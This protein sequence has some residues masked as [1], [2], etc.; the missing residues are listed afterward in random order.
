MAD[1]NNNKNAGGPGRRR[2]QTYDRRTN[3]EIDRDRHRSQQ[4][5]THKRQKQANIRATFF[6]PRTVTPRPPQQAEPVQEALLP[7]G[8]MEEPLEVVAGPLDDG[9]T[10]DNP[11][12]GVDLSNVPLLFRRRVGQ[13]MHN[14]RGKMKNDT[15]QSNQHVRYSTGSQNFPW[16][17]PEYSWGEPLFLLRNP[18]VADFFLSKFA[19]LIFFAVDKTAPHLLPT[20][21]MPCKWHGFHVMDDGHPCTSKDI[22]F[23]NFCRTFDDADSTSGFLFS[24]RYRCRLQQGQLS[25]DSNVNDVSDHR[26]YF[27]GHDPMVLR[28]L[29]CD[30]RRRLL[31]LVLTKRR[32]ITIK[33]SERIWE[34]VTNKSSFS[35]V[36]KK[37]AS[38]RRNLVFETKEEIDS[39]Y[40]KN[41][42]SQ[43]RLT[44]M[45]LTDY[46][47]AMRLELSDLVEDFPSAQ[48]V[49]R[50][51]ILRALKMLPYY[52]RCL[53][54]VSGRILCG[55]KSY[56]VIKFVF[57]QDKDGSAVRAFDSVYTVMNEYNQVVAIN[58]V[59]A[60]DYEE[61]EQILKGIRRRYEIHGY[62]EVRL[63]Y[64]DDCCHEYKMLLRAMPS[65]G[66][67]D[68][69]GQQDLRELI[70]LPLAQLPMEPIWIRSKEA[71]LT[72][73]LP[74]LEALDA[75]SE[76]T[77]IGLDIE[78][79]SLTRDARRKQF[80]ESLQLA[81]NCNG[82]QA[83]VVISLRQT[84]PEIIKD[85]DGK[86]TVDVEAWCR[87]NNVLR[88]L[89]THPRALLV[90]VNVKGDVTRLQKN[91]PKEFIGRKGLHKIE[92]CR[93]VANKSNLLFVK[94]KQDLATLTKDFM[95]LRLDK[96][97]ARSKWSAWV[98][99]QECIQYAALDAWIGLLLYQRFESM[100]NLHRKPKKEDLKKDQLVRLLVWRSN[101]VCA[102]AQIES[103][104]LDVEDIVDGR[105]RKFDRI[106]VK[107]L[108][109]IDGAVKVPP[110]T[111]FHGED[112]NNTVG[113]VAA[114]GSSIVWR[115]DRM[116]L[117][118]PSDLEMA[119]RRFP[120]TD[121]TNPRN[122]IQNADEQNN[123]SAIRNAHDQAT[124]AASDNG[125]SNA[126]DQ[127][128]GAP[129]DLEDL[130][131]PD[132]T[133][134]DNYPDR[135]VQ[136]DSEH[137]LEFILIA[138]NDD[139]TVHVEVGGYEIF[140]RNGV[141]GDVF[142]FMKRL[143]STWKKTHGFSEEARGLVRDAILIAKPERLEEETTTLS[144]KLEAEKG[145]PWSGDAVKARAEATRR[146]ACPSG[147]VLDDIERI[148]PDP[149]TLE[150]QFK[151]VCKFV[152]NVK[153]AKTG[154]PL[155]SK[156]SWKVY[157]KTLQHIQKGCLS[158]E[159]DVNYYYFTTKPNGRKVLHCCRGTSQLEGFHRH[160][161]D[162]LKAS[163]SSPLLAVCLLAA[164]VHR[165][166]HDRA[167][168]KG[169]ASDRYS[170]FYQHD[171][172]HNL[173]I[174]AD[175]HGEEQVF[176]DLANPNDFASTGEYHYTPVVRQALQLVEAA[177]GSS[178]DN[179]TRVASEAARILSSKTVEEIEGLLF[180]SADE[181]QSVPVTK[182]TNDDSDLFQELVS[183][184]LGGE[185][186]NQHGPIDFAK[187]CILHNARAADERCKPIEERKRIFGKTAQILKEHHKYLHKKANKKQTE[188][189][190]VTIDD[191]TTGVRHATTVRRGLTQIR[192]QFKQ[193][194]AHLNFQ[195]PLPRPQSPDQPMAS[196]VQDPSERE[197]FCVP[198][199][200]LQQAP[201]AST[202]N[203]PAHIQMPVTAGHGVVIP[204]NKRIE[205]PSKSRN[206]QR[207]YRCGWERGGP[208]HKRI[209]VSNSED[210]CQVL[211]EERYPFWVVP[212]GYNVSDQKTSVASKS[213]KRRWGGIM[214]ARELPDDE[215]FPDW[216][217]PKKKRKKDSPL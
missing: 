193:T 187:M 87:E 15:K 86:Y 72:E 157:R 141:K 26:Y 151:A 133:T 75:A 152:A 217:P 17:G 148:I 186:E 50:H 195:E 179:A 108:A 49:E 52:E 125:A 121:E 205:E 64:T 70:E 134:L 71:F 39:F 1:T 191:P 65:L 5:Q 83:A 145:K 98:L 132:G 184:C 213:M 51:F 162:I 88:R 216:N 204:G 188:H 105:K 146:M 96:T 199:I 120:S 167:I 207:C 161:R 138:Q 102:F 165:W 110:V 206:P 68:P 173:Q 107:I 48:Y 66:Q 131:L 116:A 3:A 196:T 211:E 21:Q 46:N 177:A 144:S 154:E 155:F 143:F 61:V 175:L 47:K 35:S 58:F 197:I 115:R 13:V 153:D 101:A 160:L 14:L 62:E 76:L 97:L 27:A 181:S 18:E 170:E 171:T 43:L 30:I 159:S 4:E 22:F 78:W 189:Q 45:S 20:G 136:D 60:G 31:G 103:V 180:E 77:P 81:I 11:L 166:N 164:F 201:L 44:Q 158:D 19:R 192:G 185:S 33:L 150:R 130:P 36:R 40:R 139:G 85:A 140:E 6:A 89:L 156:Q 53:Q 57:V 215:R 178:G 106:L 91:F 212:P 80:P 10:D 122:P 117:S 163:F 119:Q 8:N 25:P 183:S 38:L 2:G 214:L 84:F 129:A 169:L 23:N 208:K 34:D 82:C 182:M 168:E 109:V 176:G 149:K 200:E 209:A 128:T 114:S 92:D 118:N 147:K 9:P 112:G 73:T 100:R 104:Q 42:I 55:D 90:G 67:K 99:S 113:S 174:S 74:F 63:F 69:A 12:P 111:I 142:H 202:G 127:A 28:Y 124:G 37:G 190:V 29:T 54:L 32:A 41:R 194:A 79:D 24:S 94:Q 137:D 198:P 172:V 203:A 126:H 210:Y 59:R 16:N 56:K 95:G 123:N 7:A 135:Q 93:T